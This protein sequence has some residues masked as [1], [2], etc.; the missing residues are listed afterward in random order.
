MK[1]I[2]EIKQ[3]LSNGGDLFFRG[4]R[5]AQVDY[6]SLTFGKVLVRLEGLAKALEVELTEIEDV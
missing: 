4:L 1:T 5:I 3:W 2:N 6:E